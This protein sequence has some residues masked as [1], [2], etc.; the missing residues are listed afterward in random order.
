MIGFLFLGLTLLFIAI[1]YFAIGR[2]KQML[3]MNA[4]WATIIGRVSFSGVFMAY[5]SLFIITLMGSILLNVAIYRKV[6]RFQ[7]N[8]LLLL[9]IQSLRI[10]VEFYLYKLYLEKL[11]PQ[12]MTFRGFN[13][14]IIIGVF[15]VLFLVVYLFRKSILKNWVFTLWNYAGII[16]L[17]SVVLIGIL[18]S[19]VPIQQFSFDQPNVAVLGFPYALL[20]TVIVPIA[21]LSHLLMLRGEGGRAIT[22]I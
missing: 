5:P 11:I 8:F 7:V 15:S 4:I 20:P 2:N 13:F 19:P 1:F 14:D 17:I 18:S 16:S 6:R 9:I 10:V 12:I 21:L 3:I 22:G